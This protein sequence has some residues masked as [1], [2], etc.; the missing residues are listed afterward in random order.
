MAETALIETERLAIRP[1]TLDDIEHIYAHLSDPEVMRYYPHALSR[2]ECDSWLNKILEDYG[3]NG[4]G[5]FAVCLKE[6]GEYVGQAGVMRRHRDGGE[7]FFLAY[8]IRRECWGQGYATETAR[9]LIRYGFETL[10]APKVEALIACGNSASIR[11]AE[12][13]GM[14]RAGTTVHLDAEHYIYEILK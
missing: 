2:E 14:T 4:Y 3:T 11:V 8:L 7:H 13:I 12:K 6:T 10:R 1:F 5:T 9:A